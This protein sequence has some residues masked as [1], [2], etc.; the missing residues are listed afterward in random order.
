MYDFIN[1]AK[2]TFEVKHNFVYVNDYEFLK[3]NDIYY[4]VPWIMPDKYNYGSARVNN[5]KAINNGLTF[6]NLD[7]SIKETHNWWYSDAL[8]EER[9]NKL[10]KNSKSVLV[11]EQEILKKWKEKN[12]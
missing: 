8:T 12:A 6:R 9:R 11:R 2:E 3:E 10:E 5:Q 7:V 1:E 4:I